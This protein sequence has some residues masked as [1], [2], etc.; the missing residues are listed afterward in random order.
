[1]AAIVYYTF[2]MVQHLLLNHLFLG[3]QGAGFQKAQV[4]VTASPT[5]GIKTEPM[6][7]TECF[8]GILELIQM[9][10]EYDTFE[11]LCMMEG[12]FV[13]TFV[14]NKTPIAILA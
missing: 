4:F 14:V 7:G 8:L 11:N 12:C 3:N 6:S 5:A 13:T 1:M 9:E 10:N 2:N